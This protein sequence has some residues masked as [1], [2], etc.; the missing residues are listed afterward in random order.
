MTNSSIDVTPLV[1]FIGQ[2]EKQIYEE[3]L[4]GAEFYDK[5]TVDTTVKNNKKYT[6]RV[7]TSNAR[8]F[9]ATFDSTGNKIKYTQSGIAVEALRDDY[10]LIP[11][12][13]RKTWLGQDV[14][15]T[16]DENP[17]YQGQLSGITNKLIHDLNQNILWAA[18]TARSNTDPARYRQVDGYHKQLKTAITNASSTGI[19]VVAT[20]ALTGGTGNAY[21]GTA[22]NAL[23][24]LQLMDKS[25]PL[26]LAGVPRL[27][28]MSYAT[29]YKV[30]ADMKVAIVGEATE[31]SLMKEGVL[32]LGIYPEESEGMLKLCPCRFMGTTGRI[33]ITTKDNIIFGTD[34]DLPTF[35]MFDLVKIT[36]GY[37]LSAKMVY[38]MT[39]RD[40]ENIVANELT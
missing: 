24:K 31:K 14:D 21:Q 17:D 6:K 15:I 4:V 38:G 34:T 23:L 30:I 25:G 13:F 7:V 18:D 40:Y 35:G 9:D 16:N 20:G 2:Y 11:E 22:G 3:A 27:A 8:P 33:F 37:Q 29:Y 36:H 19:V 10:T 26:A 39:F 5:V 32:G 12:E 28:Y 1:G